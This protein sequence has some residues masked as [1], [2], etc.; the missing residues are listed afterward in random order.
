MHQFYACTAIER[1]YLSHVRLGLL[2]SL[3]SSAILLKA[4]LSGRGPK[5]E[6]TNSALPLGSLF[7]AASIATIGVGWWSY[8]ASKDEMKK[9]KGFVGGYRVH[10]VVLGAVAALVA[11]TYIYLLVVG[12]AM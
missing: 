3:L 11:S 12:E 9:G 2:L 8:E 7:F 1:N 5:A 4:R 10:E 6:S